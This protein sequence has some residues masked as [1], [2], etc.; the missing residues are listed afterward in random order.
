QQQTV[1]AETVCQLLA[2]HPSM[3]KRPFLLLQ[4]QAVVGF[5]AE[6]YATIFK[7]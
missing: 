4:T 5:K 1:S 7:L 2:D 3:I 6:Q